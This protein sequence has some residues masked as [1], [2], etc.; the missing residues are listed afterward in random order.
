LNQVHLMSK[1]QPHPGHEK[2][3]CDMVEKEVPIDKLKPL[4]KNAKYICICCGRGAAKAENI[5]A[6]EAL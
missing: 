5:C 6:P 1:A 2:H 4:V 3:L